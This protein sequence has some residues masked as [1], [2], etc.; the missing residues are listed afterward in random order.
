[1]GARVHGEG[2]RHLGRA[3]LAAPFAAPTLAR[4]FVGRLGRGLGRVRPPRRRRHL[5][6]ERQGHLRAPPRRAHPR[7]ADPRGGHEI[8]GG[9]S[10]SLNPSY[11]AADVFPIAALTRGIT[12]SASS[13]IERLASPGSTPSLP[14]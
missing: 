8:V 2:A 6:R 3:R 4:L 1:A 14:P 13:C 7:D 5:G 11:A 10:L 9:V 12:S